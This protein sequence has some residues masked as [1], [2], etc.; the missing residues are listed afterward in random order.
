MSRD[1][2]VRLALAALLLAAASLADG[3]RRPRLSAERA[4]A[5][6]DEA[7]VARNDGDPERTLAAAR[8][9]LRSYPRESRYL[10]LEAAALGAMGDAA[11]EAESWELYLRWSP[12]PQEAC[13]RLGQAYE[14]LKRNDRALDAN[15]RCAGLDEHDLDNRL[16]YGRS[17]MFAGDKEKAREA[18]ESILKDAP[19][20]GDAALL[21]GRIRLDG[22][23]P[24]GG[25]ALIEPVLAKRP[26]DPDALLFGALSDLAS[27]RLPRA[28]ERLRKAIGAAPGYWDL[29]R[30]LARV[31]DAKGDP[32]CAKKAR[33]GLE[34]AP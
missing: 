32:E 25:A 15:R 21:L 16:Y 26:A 7:L 27:K 34:K 30:V 17:L 28:E 10:E 2:G 12:T 33:A 5:L 20:Y 22:G 24:A 13:P 3:T 19:S 8:R 1:S 9:L 31:C 4:A 18:F 23:D 11:G 14:K 6:W 29:Y